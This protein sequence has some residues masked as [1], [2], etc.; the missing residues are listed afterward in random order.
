M[1][2]VSPENLLKFAKEKL[3]KQELQTLHRKKAFAVEVK[4]GC[5]Y[6]TPRSTHKKPRPHDGRYLQDVCDRFSKKQSYHPSD[7]RDL[8]YNASYILAIIRR[9]VDSGCSV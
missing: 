4:E 2:E 9:Y 7:Y 8:T 6:F 3:D 5:L 1:L